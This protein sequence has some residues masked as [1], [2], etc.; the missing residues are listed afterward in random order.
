M[1]AIRRAVHSGTQIGVPIHTSEHVRR[2]W[3]EDGAIYKII[4]LI[5][6]LAGIVLL[7]L[8]GDFEM[9]AAEEDFGLNR[10][11]PR[12]DSTAGED[13]MMKKK[14]IVLDEAYARRWLFL[15]SF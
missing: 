2:G 9:V 4:P 5:H 6:R 13:M 1:S 14:G 12:E 15:Q 3:R 8:V 11:E 10:D 7:A